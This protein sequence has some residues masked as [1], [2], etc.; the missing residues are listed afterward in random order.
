MPAGISVSKFRQLVIANIVA[1][2]YSN[3]ESKAR[4]LGPGARKTVLGLLVDGHQPRISRQTYAR[5]DAI[6]YAISKF[7][8]ASTVT[9]FGFDSEYGLHNHV[10]GL[11]AYVLDVDPLRGAQFMER[12]RAISTSWR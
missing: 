10:G 12:Y 3:N 7:G 4:V 1:A 11:V 6:L 9:H 2:G 5:V 8:L